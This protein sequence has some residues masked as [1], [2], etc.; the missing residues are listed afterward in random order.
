MAP[1]SPRSRCP[2]VLFLPE[3]TGGV[4]AQE[5]RCGEGPSL[6]DVSTT[7]HGAARLQLPPR[8]A[9]GAASR[10]LE[11][12]QGPWVQLELLPRE[13]SSRRPT[14]PPAE[15]VCVCVSH[16]PP[17]PPRELRASVPSPQR[18][19][20]VP[21]ARRRRLEPMGGFQSSPLTPAHLRV[22]TG[23][24]ASQVVSPT[25]RLVVAPSEQGGSPRLP[26]PG[27]GPGESPLPQSASSV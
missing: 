11:H 6:R 19:A 20:R 26:S 10:V 23:H 9:A 17:P 24:S 13:A 7:R 5:A 16:C 8:P 3:C 12:L 21:S 15:A 18:K 14:S 1:S 27:L 25:G 4:D 2:Q 22:P